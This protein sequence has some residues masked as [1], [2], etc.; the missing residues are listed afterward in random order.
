MLLFPQ[1]RPEKVVQKDSVAKF[2]EVGVPEEWVPVLQ[3]AGYLLVA[4]L[5]G[6]NPQKIHQ[7]VCGLNKKYKLGYTNV[8]VDQVTEWVGRS[9]N[10]Q[11]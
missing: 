8:T 9:V 1:M 5:A 10:L 6:V 2:A 11:K 4:D 7:D 3:K